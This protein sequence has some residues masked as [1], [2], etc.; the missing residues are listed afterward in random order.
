MTSTRLLVA[1]LTTPAVVLIGLVRPAA[2]IVLVLL[3]A[4]VAAVARVGLW[5]LDDLVEGSPDGH[6][7]RAGAGAFVAAVAVATGLLVLGPASVP[8]LAVAS[9]V[10]TVLLVRPVRS[11]RWLRPDGCR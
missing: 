7:L 4:F 6:A 11:A 3:G 8:V 2:L 5:L 1:A 10:V 9:V